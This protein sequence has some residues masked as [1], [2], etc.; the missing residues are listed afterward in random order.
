[1]VRLEAVVPLEGA[2]VNPVEGSVVPV[3][4]LGALVKVSEPP[5]VTVVIF[6]DIQVTT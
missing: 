3:P 2:V 5:E 1:M 6:P 4:E